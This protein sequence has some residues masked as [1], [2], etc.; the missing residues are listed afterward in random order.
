MYFNV[1]IIDQNTPGANCCMPINTDED[2]NIILGNFLKGPKGDPLTYED[3]TEE[4]IKNLQQPAIDA[5]EVANTAAENATTAAVNVNL[6]TEN[7]NNAAQSANTAAGNVNLATENANNAAQSANTAAG[8]VNTAITNAETAATNAQNVADTYASQLANKVDKV[9]GKDLSSNDYTTQEKNKLAEIE[10]KAQKNVQSDYSIDDPTDDRYIKNKVT[11]IS[12]LENDQQ[13]VKQSDLNTEL[14]KKADLADGKVP[15]SQLPSFVDDILEFATLSAF[16]TTGE[17]GKIYVTL[18]TNLTYRWSG[19]G[20][21]EISPSLALGETSSTAYR[22][23][24]GEIAYN[25]SQSAH[26]PSDAQKNVQSDYSVDDPDDDAYIKNKVTK[27]SQLENDQQFVKQSDLDVE[28]NEIREILENMLYQDQWYGVMRTKESIDSQLI[29]IGN[30]NL[31]RDL[32][33]QNKLKRFIAN[34]D[35]TVKYYLHPN[36]SRLKEDGTPAIIDSTDG[37]VML[38]VP[39]HYVY[40]MERGNEMIYAISEHNIPGFVKVP[41]RVISAFM[42]T[43][44]NI[45]DEVVSGC[46]LTWNGNEIARDA[47]NLPIFTDNAAQFRGGGNNADRDGTVQSDLGMCRTAIAKN[48]MRSKCV[49]TSHVGGFRA[50]NTI[51]WFQRIEYANTDCQL[52]FNPELTVDGF[53][54]GGLGHTTYFSGA[55]WSVHNEFYPFIP[56]GITAVLG[57]NS[58]LVDYELQM[59]SGTKLFKAHSYRGFEFPYGYI[60]QHFDD[61]LAYKI[62]SSFNKAY[63]CD[64]YTKFTSPADT[65]TEV[66]DGYVLRGTLPLEPCYPLYEKVNPETGLSFPFIAGGSDVTGMCDYYYCRGEDANGWYTALVGG[67]STSSATSGFGCLYTDNRSSV[68]SAITGFRLCHD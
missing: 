32:P 12:Q 28:L 41:R 62:G 36:D 11:K 25:H 33:L 31:H 55:E 16:P 46:F 24:R 40:H 42:S 56:N 7:A 14:S 59:A 66:P 44:D 35:G 39:E 50:Y 64:D 23:D 27:V 13:F 9:E 68:T 54:Q 57:N 3:L 18:D 38:E 52:D 67:T 47:N 20:Y 19:S 34:P 4:Q 15:A 43:I 30:F 8:N 5:A 6:A 10:A 58:G 29:R 21:V 45:N 2:L 17:A 63:V 48:T 37:N 53:K 60:W 65:Q 22:G 49:G 51:R 26:A 61:L 1:E